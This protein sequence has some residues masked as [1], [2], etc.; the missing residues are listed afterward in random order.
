MISD[1]NTYVLV[2]VARAYA[3]HMHVAETKRTVVAVGHALDTRKH[4]VLKPDT[5]AITLFNLWCR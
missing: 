1:Y 2:V 3:W 4:D 5:Y